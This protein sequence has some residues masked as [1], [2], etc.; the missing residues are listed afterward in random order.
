MF[1]AAGVGGG[2]EGL[3]QGIQGVTEDTAEIIAA[4]MN[5]IRFDVAQQN[6]KLDTIVQAL[7]L[8]TATNPLIHNLRIIAQQ[9]TDIRVLLDSVVMPNHPDG[10]S[11]IKVFMD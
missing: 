1:Q 5:T 7:Q 10:G 4:Y 6:S 8:D 3:Q 2:L 9:T 11:G